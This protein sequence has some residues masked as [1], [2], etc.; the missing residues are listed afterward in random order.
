MEK[1]C[2]F[3]VWAKSAWLV[4]SLP[5]LSD[6]MPS[7]TS[8]P[9]L[10]AYLNLGGQKS[11]REELMRIPPKVVSSLMLPLSVTILRAYSA[12]YSEEESKEI[13]GQ[14]VEVLAAS[15]SRRRKELV[16]VVCS[17][18]SSVDL[19]S[20]E[21]KFLISSFDCRT[22]DANHFA[23]VKRSLPVMNHKDLIDILNVYCSFATKF[24]NRYS[25]EK[26]SLWF[27]WVKGL[28]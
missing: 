14:V 21:R 18:F 13:V 1:I 24:S 8:W 2:T 9:L 28:W 5:D 7:S 17:E 22:L 25:D 15:R 6:F 3:F 20:S 4:H 27:D 26:R 16:S 23:Y 11:T 12:L 19:S 10:A